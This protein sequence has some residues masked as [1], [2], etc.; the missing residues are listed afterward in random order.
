MPPSAA[1]TLQADLRPWLR[2]GTG[3]VSLI[4]VPGFRALQ[5]HVPIKE[6]FFFLCGALSLHVCYISLGPQLKL[7]MWPGGGKKTP[8]R[9]GVTL[10]TCGLGVC[11]PVCW[12][13]ANQ[14]GKILGGTISPLGVPIDLG[15][16][17][18][19]ERRLLSPSLEDI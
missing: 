15:S 7:R 1:K 17:I 9:E 11:F 8:K 19:L 2:P 5:T 16:C 3:L 18:F 4:T 14:T 10:L 13:A 6:I 12:E